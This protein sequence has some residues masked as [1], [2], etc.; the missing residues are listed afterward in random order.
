MLLVEVASKRFLCHALLLLQLLLLKR[1]ETVRKLTSEQAGEI[2][3]CCCSVFRGFIFIIMRTKCLRY[4][5]F[6][7]KV[8]SDWL[9]RVNCVCLADKNT[10]C[11]CRNFFTAAL[12]A[13]L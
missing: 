13:F 12:E 11:K 2:L 5:L 3:G 6:Y 9:F 7:A 8:V 4:P 10:F 1:S